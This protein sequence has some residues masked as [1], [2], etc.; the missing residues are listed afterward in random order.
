MSTISLKVWSYLERRTWPGFQKT[1]KRA[2]AACRK[3]R[4]NQD[5]AENLRMA[6]RKNNANIIIL[7]DF[8]FKLGQC[9]FKV[10]QIRGEW[11]FLG[12]GGADFRRFFSQKIL[13]KK[14]AC[15]RFEVF[16]NPAR[17]PTQTKLLSLIILDLEYFGWL[18]L[19]NIKVSSQ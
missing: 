9:Y 14:R 4:S 8:F 5:F 16:W 18:T 2:S 11:H 6:H 13:S 10:A 7:A 19:A 3:W 17:N 1:L 12:G 15:R